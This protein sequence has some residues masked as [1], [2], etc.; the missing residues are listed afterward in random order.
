MVTVTLITVVLHN[1]ALAVL[2]GVVI[3]ALVFA[4]ENAK[5]IHA[6]RYIDDSGVKHYE[7]IGPLF[8]ASV[9]T[10]NEKF[11]VVND[12]EEV[13]IDFSGSKIVDMSGIEAVNKLTERY[14][15]LGKKLHLK[16]LSEDCRKLLHNA[17][18]IIEVNIYEDP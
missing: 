7:M 17:N 3:S 2:I 12:P 1:L 8:F 13:I 6:K 14:Q 18:D 4:W 10:F 16:H 9:A 5:H 15:K 11:D